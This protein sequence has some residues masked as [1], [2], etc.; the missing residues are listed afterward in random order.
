MSEFVKHE[1]CPKCGSRDNLA[2]YTDGHAWCF[3]CGYFRQPKLE[4]RIQQAFTPR[5]VPNTGESQGVVALPDDF[6][7]YVP[8][9]A[10]TWLKKYG[11]MSS[12]ISD[13]CF[14]WSEEKQLLIMPVFSGSSCNDKDSR[15]RLLMWQGRYFGPDKDHPKYITKGSPEQILHFIDN[16]MTDSIILTEDLISAIKVGRQFCAAPLWGSVVS[17]DRIIRLSKMTNS[18]MIWLD[19]D[20]RADA[21]KYRNRAA[22]YIPKVGVIRTE[23][24]PKEYNDDQIY[25]FV[26][27]AVMKA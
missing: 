24:D 17:L 18:L 9:R 19:A 2:T 6:M 23:R 14:G 13:N 15:G 10:L 11:I 7:S 1:G 25:T 16:M 4:A 22:Q 5:L 20:K 27:E 8:M 21:I 26:T 3:G 12:E